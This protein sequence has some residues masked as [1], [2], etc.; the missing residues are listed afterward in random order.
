MSGE[1]LECELCGR[2]VPLLTRH[3]LIPRA[4]HHNKRNK[5]EFE[6]EDVVT[7]IALLCTACHGQVHALFTLKELEREFNTIAALA[8]YPEMARFVKWVR[9]QPSDRRVAHRQSNDKAEK[10]ARRRR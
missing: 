3:H 10:R 4:R 8:E 7:R 6:R 5:R 2:S 1:G 9:K